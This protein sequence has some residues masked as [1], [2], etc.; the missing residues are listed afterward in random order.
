MAIV[1]KQQ[2]G[3]GRKVYILVLKLCITIAI[4]GNYS[5]RNISIFLWSIVDEKHIASS[6]FRKAHANSA[7]VVCVHCK[8]KNGMYVDPNV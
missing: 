4:A 7:L 3:D 5:I 8:L 6:V 1:S 2:L